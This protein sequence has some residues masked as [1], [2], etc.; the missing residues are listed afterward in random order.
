MI[1]QSQ[2]KLFDLPAD[3]AYLNCAYMSPL[4]KDVADAGRKG[5]ASKER[6]WGV[7]PVD[8]FTQSEEARLLFAD[9]VGASMDDIAIV[10]AASYALNIAARNLPVGRGQNILTLSDQFP[11]NVYCWREKAKA[12]GATVV[13]IKAPPDGDLTAT[14]LAAIDERTALA[15]LPHCLWT[16]GSL[17]D[18]ERVGVA[19]R[20][21]GAALV[22]DATQSLG[23]LPLDIAKVQP[24]FLVA[25]CYKWL[26][27]PYSLGFLY[28][29]PKWQEGEPL[30]Y[31][32]IAREGSE[33][34]ARLVDY[35]DRYQVGARRF[36]VGERSNF[37]LMPM[38]TVALKRILDWGVANIQ[39]TLAV[40]NRSIVA[41]AE[42]LGLTAIPEAFRAGHYLGLRFAE[43]AP[44]NLAAKLSEANVYVTYG[45][46]ACG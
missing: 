6:P 45:A 20:A 32:W 18:L 1:I 43:K 25:A 38:A 34:F 17:I 36:D 40:R 22:V 7:K 31:S 27:G 35:S 41:R 33:N 46:L 24:D 16:D 11:S 8:F 26:L 39:E 30:E 42:H 9:L 4:M 21:V 23:A 2:R 3:V 28:A 44:E 5:I 14:V 37:V 19:L 15:A 29:A 12:V 10:P 13:A